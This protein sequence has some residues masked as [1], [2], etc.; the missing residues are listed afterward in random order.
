M[1]RSGFYVIRCPRCGR[2]TFAPITQKTR[3]CVYCHRIFKVNPLDAQYVE[4]AKTATTLVKFYNTGK[5]HEEFME[6]VRQSR[7]QVVALVPSQNIKLESLSDREGIGTAT[8]SR[9]RR[10]EEILYKYARGTGVE[11]QVLEEECLKAGLP[12]DWVSQQ[13]EALKRSGRIVCPRPWLVRIVASVDRPQT[14][15][16]V[17]NYSLAA[18]ARQIGDIIRKAERPISFMDL[19]NTLLKKGAPTAQI[20]KA[21][22]L[23]K[24]Q[25][26]IFKTRDGG[27]CWTGK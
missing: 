1:R 3:F 22:E 4:D 13:L 2:Y 17:S 25:G 19:T 18:L 8:S 27:Y 7:A 10:L 12:W 20:E 16:T 5:H 9:R 23:L 14:G 24:V 26:Y 15:K 11:L 21:I 6:A